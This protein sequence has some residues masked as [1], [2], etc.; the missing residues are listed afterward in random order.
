MR[1]A[2]APRPSNREWERFAHQALDALL[3]AQ[4]WPAWWTL[5]NRFCRLANRPP[6]PAY[7]ILHIVGRAETCYRKALRDE[8]FA[9]NKR[10]KT[11][12]ANFWKTV[13]A[14]DEAGLLRC[15]A[16]DADFDHCT[17]YVVSKKGRKIL[18]E[19]DRTAN[20]HW[21]RVD[22]ERHR[23]VQAWFHKRRRATA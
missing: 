1:R 9:A 14:L 21:K 10:N 4:Q 22:E 11:L 16:A 15:T 7:Q 13:D 12:Q 3:R 6:E 18:A 8:V 23:R 17:D 20:R 2:K 19:W 5:A